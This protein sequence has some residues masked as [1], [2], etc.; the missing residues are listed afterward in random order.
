MDS[1]LKESK[2]QKLKLSDFEV[3][4]PLGN[5]K[6]G[7]VYLARTK[8]EKFIV[9]LKAMFKTQ[10]NKENMAH[11]LRREIEIQAHLKHPNILRMY[12]YFWD[13]DTI[14]LVLEYAPRGEL[15][16]CLQK[17]GRFDDQKAAN[18]SLTH[19]TDSF[20]TMSLFSL[21]TK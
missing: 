6:F 13:D 17:A 16:K 8:K 11:Q 18:V 21:F 1:F 20:L 4:R 15:Y 12:G 14:F 2:I 7:H 5:G 3:G 19:L 9:A 10:L